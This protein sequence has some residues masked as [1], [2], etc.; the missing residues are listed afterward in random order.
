MLYSGAPRVSVRVC[1]CVRWPRSLESCMPGLLFIYK[2][3][4]IKNIQTPVTAS[5]LVCT[6]IHI[7]SLGMYIHT[8]VPLHRIRAMYF[9]CKN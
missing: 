1:V 2:H 7:Y 8:Y 4:Y 5:A 9:Q 6:Y 3:N